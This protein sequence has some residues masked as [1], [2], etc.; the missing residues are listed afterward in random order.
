MAVKAKA[1]GTVYLNIVVDTAGR[2]AS[3]SVMRGLPC[4]LNSQAI[5]TV[6]QWRLKPAVDP[7][8]SPVP[9]HQTVEVTFHLY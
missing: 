8:G 9:V 6:K 1:Q 4:G 3:I 2:P 7:D 5:E